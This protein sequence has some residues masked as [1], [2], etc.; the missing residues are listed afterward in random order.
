MIYPTTSI[1][2]KIEHDL[3]QLLHE[4]TPVIPSKVSANTAEQPAMYY[5]L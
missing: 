2:N 5:I 1:S 3:K 4:E